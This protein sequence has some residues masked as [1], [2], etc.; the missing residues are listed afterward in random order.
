MCHGCL[1]KTLGP[2]VIAQFE[3]DYSARTDEK[4]GIKFWKLSTKAD[5]YHTDIECLRK[6]RPNMTFTLDNLRVDEGAVLTE[7][8]EKDLGL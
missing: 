7:S 8:I 2:G 1:K 5:Y 4:N 3:L 6:R